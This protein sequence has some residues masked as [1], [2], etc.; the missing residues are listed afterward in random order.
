MK[1][2]CP[3]SCLFNGRSS[4]DAQKVVISFFV[5]S[6]GKCYTVSVRTFVIPFNPDPVPP[7]QKIR[8]RS[9]PKPDPQYCCDHGMNIYLKRKDGGYFRALLLV[10]ILK[11]GR[12]VQLKKNHQ[13]CL[14]ADNLFGSVCLLVRGSTWKIEPG[15]FARWHLPL[16][17]TWLEGY[18]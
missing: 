11:N 10:G 12:F 16:S 17:S 5:F 6:P 9:N 4:I 15:V 3:N 8:I 18:H 13:I 2:D 1:N 7:G 14:C